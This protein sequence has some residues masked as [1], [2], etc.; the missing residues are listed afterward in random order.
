MCGRFT[1]T[2]RDLAEVAA[3]LEAEFSAEDAARY[4]PRYNAAP[5]D[6]HFVLRLEGDRRRLVPAVWG[7]EGARTPIVINARAET[8]AQKP[9]FREAFR[10]RRCVV[11]A[12]GFFEWTPSNG[13]KQP[14]WFH[15]PDGKLVPLAGLYD[16]EPGGAIRF[17]I[18]TT[19]ANDLVRPIHD[20]MPVVLSHG[21]VGAWLEEPISE[22][23]APAPEGMLVATA[24]S[25]RVNDVAN[26]D[27]ECLAPP[28]PPAEP[29][30]RRGQLK[31]F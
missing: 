26:D 8:A 6:E 27:P 15:A 12:D 11:P 14:I 31:L 23:L 21:A 5:T 28:A 9:M 20:R 16:V 7:L 1:L 30:P 25:R 3:E 17:V 18:L 22:L 29:R 13:G 24:V 19:E 2:R 4:R 10:Q